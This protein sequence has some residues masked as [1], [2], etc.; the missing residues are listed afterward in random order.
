M[1]EVFL[2]QVKIGTMNENR[3][4]RDASLPVYRKQL[5][6]RIEEVHIVMFV[7]GGY[8]YVTMNA[9]KGHRIK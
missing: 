6:R 8:V 7:N 1:K 9:M 2:F 4:Q 3:S 5:I